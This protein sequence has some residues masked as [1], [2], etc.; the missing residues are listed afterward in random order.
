MKRI[1]TVFLQAVVVL[2]GMVTLVLLIRLPLTEGRAQNLDLPSIY[3]DPLILYG[4][5]VSIAFFIALHQ[6][7]K[8][9][10]YIGQHRAFSPKAAKTL[11]TIK[12]CAITLSVSIVVAG[13]YIRIT[14]SQEDDPA[15]FLAMCIMTALA[16]IV[17]ATAAAML[18]K[19]L[20]HA[21]DMKSENE[22]TI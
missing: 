11:K 6:A 22:L 13:V 15:G 2:I 12:Y 17:V 10:Q 21:V 18:E 5:A 3:L 9:L 14:H 19:L 7:F 1:S 20:Q 16:S 4:Y 8:L